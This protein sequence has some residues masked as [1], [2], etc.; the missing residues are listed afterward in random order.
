M[1]LRGAQCLNDRFDNR[2]R[3]RGTSDCG[4]DLAGQKP[5][6]NSWLL[7]CDVTLHELVGVLDP[8]VLERGDQPTC[9]PRGLAIVVLELVDP[10]AWRWRW[11]LRLP[12][13]GLLLV[14]LAS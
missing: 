14:A 4:Q 13:P 3:L 10:R 1:H 11:R 12:G 8:L 6:G 2:L 7:T 9:A 5:G